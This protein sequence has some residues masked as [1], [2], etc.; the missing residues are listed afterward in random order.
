MQ[1]FGGQKRCI[2]ADVQIAN[3]QEEHEMHGFKEMHEV[4]LCTED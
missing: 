2:M 3:A 1:N 4:N